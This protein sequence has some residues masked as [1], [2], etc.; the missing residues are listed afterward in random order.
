MLDN[1]KSH[2]FKSFE[3]LEVS[4]RSRSA[5]LRTVVIYRPPESKNNEVTKSDF[6]VDF[7][8]LLALLIQLPGYLVIGGDFNCRESRDTVKL[9]DLLDSRGLVQHVVEATHTS[10]Q[11]LDLIITCA[12]DQLITDVR[13]TDDL[14]PDHSLVHFGINM[15]RPPNAK[16][17]RWYRKLSAMDC[18]TLSDRIQ[19]SFSDFP[20]DARVDQ[21]CDFY[22]KS[23]SKILDELSPVT[24]KTVIENPR[25]PWYSDELLQA[26]RI[27]V[28]ANGAPLDCLYTTKST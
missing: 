27:L 25:A 13:V 5:L 16:S 10:G 3:C 21:L 23:M 4:L 15:S 6:L 1:K 28:C 18:D 8:A 14:V 19:S 11:T 7:S 17:V 9:L 24:S 26:R 2:S 12:S 22:D 20:A